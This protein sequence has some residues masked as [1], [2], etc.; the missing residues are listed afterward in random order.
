M[1]CCDQTKYIHM[2]SCAVVVASLSIPTVDED[3]VKDA[4]QASLQW[5]QM[6]KN[7]NRIQVLYLQSPKIAVVFTSKEVAEELLGHGS[8]HFQLGGPLSA[9]FSNGDAF[10]SN[11]LE[12][13]LRSESEEN[14]NSF[15]EIVHEK[16]PGT[17]ALCV[18]QKGVIVR[19][20][21]A[22]MAMHGS[23][24]LPQHSGIVKFSRLL[25][26][27]D[28]V[29]VRGMWKGP[30]NFSTQ[31]KRLKAT[32]QNITNVIQSCLR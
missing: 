15:V 22:D 25:S 3:K 29:L 19:F 4:L 23:T 9:I 11:C 14:L 8:N 26:A 7:S 16:F 12:I 28:H 21:T 27:S 17:L 31:A 2:N 30:L 20:P 5:G 18:R 13:E 1:V 6:S 24:E 32:G 10:A